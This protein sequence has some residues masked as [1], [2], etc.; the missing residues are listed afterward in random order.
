MITIIIIITIVVVVVVII[1]INRSKSMK[2]VA[3]HVKNGT[4]PGSQVGTKASNIIDSKQ[5]T[6][7]RGKYKDAC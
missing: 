7:A 5:Q 3:Q 2:T 4:M 6:R 1:I